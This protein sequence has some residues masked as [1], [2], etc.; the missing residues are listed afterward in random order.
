VGKSTLFNAL[1]HSASAHAANFPFCTIDAQEGT[2][3]VPDP[4][5]A[6]LAELNR[7]ERVMPATLTFVDI[8]G[9][10]AGAS[11]GEGMGN[12]FLQDIRG[13][14]AVVHV[15]RCHPDPDVVHVLEGDVDPVRDAAII[16]AELA[17]ADL[18]QVERRRA[19]AKGKGRS[20]PSAEELRALP[21]IEAA[22]EEGLPARAALP[23]LSAEEVEAVRP[24]GLLTLKPMIYAG[25]RDPDA[26]TAACAAA[27][28]N[29]AALRRHAEAEGAGLVEVCAQLEAEVAELDEAERAEFLEDAG[30]GGGASGL[31]R[32]VREARSLLRLRTFFTSGP[33]E[34]RA[35]TVRAGTRAPAAAGTIHSDFERGFI[36]AETVGYEECVA[37]C[38]PG[39]PVWEAGKDTFAAAKELGLM[40]SEGKEYEVQ[41]GDVM[42]FRFNV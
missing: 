9:L 18:A 33:T 36:R 10:V 38:G 21:Q 30:V 12:K 8:A 25:V 29:V 39:N 27:D 17:L 26:G 40:R 42:L 4:R 14:D 41:D 5:L 35:W 24:L 22:L 1:T 23:S 37:R 3:V 11:R 7:S 32:L 20:A 15:V 16:N 6:K 2:V 34:S 13:V 19:R 31:E 28:A